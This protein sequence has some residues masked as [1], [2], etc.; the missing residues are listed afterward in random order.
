LTGQIHDKVFYQGIEYHLV[1]QNGEGLFEPSTYG[2]FPT[3]I[4]TACWRGY[5]CSYAIEQFDLL[6]TSL[7]VRT[8]DLRYPPIDGIAPADD[9][10]GTMRYTDLR[11]SMEFRGKLL[12]GA[13]FIRE[14]YV[15][16][17]FQSAQSYAKVT[18]LTFL[19]GKLISTQDRSSDFPQNSPVI[20]PPKL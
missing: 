16:M 18:E 4:H 19:A 14:K 5:Y 2:M 3:M 1:S 20:P 10:Y 13:D 9:G 6:L 12:L 7:T 11:L 15:H 8:H 17:G